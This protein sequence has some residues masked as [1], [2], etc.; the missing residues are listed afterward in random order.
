MKHHNFDIVYV[1]LET[2][3]DLL[4]ERN[5]P[6]N[7]NIFYQTFSLLFYIRSH[8][9]TRPFTIVIITTGRTGCRSGC[10]RFRKEWI[11][12]TLSFRLS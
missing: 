4:M 1:I 9:T 6:F 7:V 8:I 2:K 3:V 11:P 5:R 10:S 12:F